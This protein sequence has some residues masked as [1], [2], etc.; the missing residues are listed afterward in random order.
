M[1]KFSEYLAE[2]VRTYRFQVKLAFFPDNVMINAIENALQKYSLVSIT[3]PRSL[4]IQRV[5]RD[6][7]GTNSPETYAFE[8]ELEY[9][10]PAHFVQH[11]I[12][13]AGFALEQVCVKDPDHEAS[14]EKEENAIAKNTEDAPLLLKDYDPQDNEKISG[15]NF[16]DAYN[17]RFVKDS[18]G[19]T[20]QI[21]PKVFKEFKGKTT[22]DP[23]YTI[24]TKSAVGS[25]KV[26][27]PVVKS[28]AR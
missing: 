24:G 2:S 27:M 17:K 25:T 12:A 13:N 23:E 16:G 21:I 11:T 20:D 14:I 3:K 8:V 7:P 28:F 26:T 19:S 4:P 18:I 22:N 6:F 5:D 1:K 15:E 9:P 10:A